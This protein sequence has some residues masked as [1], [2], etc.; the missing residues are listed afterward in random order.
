MLVSWPFQVTINSAPWAAR[1]ASAIRCGSAGGF[2]PEAD[3]QPFYDAKNRLFGR[4]NR[5]GEP[6]LRRLHPIA[7]A[8][9]EKSL[10]RSTRRHGEEQRDGW[11]VLLFSSARRCQKPQNDSV[12]GVGG[13]MRFSY[14]VNSS[15]KAVTGMTCAAHDIPVTLLS[16]YLLRP[17][18]LR[19]LSGKI[20][21]NS[22]RSSRR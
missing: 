11:S 10:P 6:R 4:A 1:G 21:I 22:E 17:P 15:E 18:C 7:D 8:P 16:S 9:A 2:P 13:D 20:L 5:P 14:S 12:G 3:R 19:D